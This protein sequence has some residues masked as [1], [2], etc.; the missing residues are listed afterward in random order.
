MAWPHDPGRGFTK[1]TWIGSGLLHHFIF[2]SNFIYI[3]LIAFFYPFLKFIF[4]FEFHPSR[5]LRI[6]FVNLFNVMISISWLVS[7]IWNAN[8]GWH[9]SYFYYL[10]LHWLYC[11]IL[12]VNIGV[13]KYRVFFFI[14]LNLISLRMTWSH[15]PGHESA[16]LTRIGLRFFFHFFSS[17]NIRLSWNSASLFFSLL[18]IFFL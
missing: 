6:G 10:F 4:F 11:L 13:I 3:L 16:M 12:V 8:S 9:Q 7:R 17:F 14:F 5:L 2:M 1:L 18:A 15:D